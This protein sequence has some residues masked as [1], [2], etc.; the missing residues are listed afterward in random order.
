MRVTPLPEYQAEALLTDTDFAPIDA[1][2][3]HEA[4]EHGLDLH[5]GHGRSVWCQIETGEFGAKKRGANVLVFARAHRPEWL[6]G[7]QETIAHHLAE[8]MPDKAQAM[9]WSSLA[10][11]GRLPPYFSF[12]RVGEARRIARDFVRLRL[13]APDLERLG[14]EDSIHF[15]LVLPPEGVAE[16]EWPRIAPNGQ[17]VW[18]SGDRALHRPAYTVRAIDLQE[19]WLDTDIFLH[20]G[21]RVT[22][23]VLA[24]PQGRRIGLSGPGGGG[25][26]QAA[27]LI[28]AGDETAYPAIARM[29][30]R[31]PDA[32]GE[33]W[34]LGARDD[35]PMPESPGL[36]RHH[37]PGGTAE[38]VRILRA[39]PPQPDSY[40]WMAAQKSGIS[41]LRQ[42]L[43]AELGHDKALTHLAGYWIG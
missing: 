39:D 26:P 42:L 16:P 5:E 36:R 24:G 32:Q 12:A 40:L 43:L 15:R 28:L 7:L 22:D 25:I 29:I 4:Q 34:L 23:W 6:F 27:Q 41:A 33:V 10:D 20:R 9:R 21:G 30:E 38:L 31:R 13:H 3:R 2:L 19:G 11:V 14:T 35:Y 17:T 18:P 8:I 37:L 1:M